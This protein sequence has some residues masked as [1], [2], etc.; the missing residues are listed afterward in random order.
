MVYIHA[1]GSVN[2]TS[3]GS[4][5]LNPNT[6]SAHPQSTTRTTKIGEI[7]GG[8]VGG[9][10]FIVLLSGLVLYL[11]RRQRH[12]VPIFLTSPFTLPECAETEGT[13]TTSPTSPKKGIQSPLSAWTSSTLPFSPAPPKLQVKTR[14]DPPRQEPVVVTSPEEHTNLSPHI[15]SIPHD[16]EPHARYHA[17][18][19]AELARILNA[20]LQA[21]D[22]DMPPSYPQSRIGI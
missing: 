2:G 22:D 10:I 21:L 15:D 6:P 5:P 9:V 16:E 4:N 1:I 13:V 3:S 20:R 14:L 18:S 8:V 19:T 11:R 17:I 7:V 12:K